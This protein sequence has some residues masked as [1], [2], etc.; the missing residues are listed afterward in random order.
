M[1]TPVVR[2]CKIPNPDIKYGFV[3]IVLVR[4]YFYLLVILGFDGLDPYLAEDFE[5]EGLFQTYHTQLTIPESIP[6]HTEVIWPTI[7]SGVPPEEHGLGRTTARKWNNSILELLAQ[8]A[9]TV[10]PRRL[11]M[12]VG[13]KIIQMG[14][15]RSTRGGPDYFNSQGLETIFT[16]LRS[17]V[18]GVPG[19]RPAEETD[20]LRELGGHSTHNPEVEIDELI[21]RLEDER[22]T[23]HQQTL[24][25]LDLPVNMLMV[26]S[27]STDMVGHLFW[28][29][30][31]FLQSWYEKCENVVESVN[32]SLAED[33]TLMVLSDHGMDKGEHR[34]EAFF[35]MSE[36]PP[37]DPETI[38]DFKPL[39]DRMMKS[40]K[41]GHENVTDRMKGL[42]YI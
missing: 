42:G 15:E 31:E 28:D 12:P 40:L 5:V 4:R 39:V 32:Q 10:L 20:R 35:S 14:F 18:I 17:K 36:S 37:F 1:N 13:K 41:Q 2:N 38:L 7:I 11:I 22:K 3:I 9:D 30:R 23:R 6:L 8:F 19:Y 24:E 26:Y 21:T 34:R 25:H 33:D 29:D 27:Y 16:N